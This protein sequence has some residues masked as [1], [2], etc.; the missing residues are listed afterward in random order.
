MIS[1]ANALSSNRFTHF[2]RLNVALLHSR[3]FSAAPGRE[4]EYKKKFMQRPFGINIEKEEEDGP[5]GLIV[6]DSVWRD[7]EKGSRMHEVSYFES[8]EKRTVVIEKGAAGLEQLKKVKVPCEITFKVK[9]ENKEKEVEDSDEEFWDEI[10]NKE[11]IDPETNETKTIKDKFW[12]KKG[13]D[14]P[15]LNMQKDE[16]LIPPEQEKAELD[17]F[18][19]SIRLEEHIDRFKSMTH[20]ILLRTNDMKALEI[21]VQHRRKIQNAKKHWLQYQN[22]IKYGALPYMNADGS[23]SHIP[24]AQK[25]FYGEISYEQQSDP[26]GDVKKHMQFVWFPAEYPVLEWYPPEYKPHWLSPAAPPS[27]PSR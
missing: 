1:R 18:L 24:G 7:V 20:L 15:W 10:E 12:W 6:R 8:G 22:V 25:Q 23:R 16:P 27:F 19:K 11:I 2:C 14:K 26:D 3:R 4:F 5:R 17:R 13:H 21:P 9:A